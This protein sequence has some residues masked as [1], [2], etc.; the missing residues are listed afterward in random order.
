VRT[1]LRLTSFDRAFQALDID[2]LLA[3]N[4]SLVLADEDQLQQVCLNLLLNARDAMAGGGTLILKTFEDQNEIY[5][6]IAD[7]GTGVN[8]TDKALIFDPFFTTKS[9]GKGTGL[10]LAICYGI[11]TEHGGRIEVT[12]VQ[13]SG[14]RFTVIIP[15]ASKTEIQ[16]SDI[17]G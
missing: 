10:G 14:T 6:E 3:D 17:G 15:A 5:V 7:S 1:A 13:P 11:V 9:A 2:T 16:A 12:D 8:E 4:T